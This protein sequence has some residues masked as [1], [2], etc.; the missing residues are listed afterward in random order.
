ML[1]LIKRNA[2]FII[3]HL[4]YCFLKRNSEWVMQHIKHMATKRLEKL[5]PSG[6][7]IGNNTDGISHI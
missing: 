5:W 3:L 6:I 2:H 1:E 4:C 7:N